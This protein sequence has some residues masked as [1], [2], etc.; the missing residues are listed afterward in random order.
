MRTHTGEKPYKCKYCDRAFSQ[1]NDLVKHTRSHV[2]DNT[3]Q[4]KQC[5]MAFRL[6]S[7]L[8]S[9]SKMHYLE[10]KGKV[11]MK[12]P[13]TISTEGEGTFLSDKVP[14]TTTTMT[15]ETEPLIVYIKEEVQQSRSQTFQRYTTTET[16]SPATTIIVPVSDTE[17]GSILIQ[18]IQIA[19]S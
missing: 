15:T 4:C 3:Y 1:S 12:I 8:R 17:T 2:G 11:M 18:H 14:T 5:P 19:N 7:E 16:I 10:Q 6:H 9:H 13:S